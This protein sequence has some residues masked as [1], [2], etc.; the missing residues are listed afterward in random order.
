PIYTKHDPVLEN[1]L[2]A[3]TA[4]LDRVTADQRRK[5][6]YKLIDKERSEGKRSITD[7]DRRRWQLPEKGRKWEHWMVPF[8]TGPDWPKEWVEAVT[9][10]RRAWRAK[11]D[12]VN[13]CIAANAEQ[14]ELVDQPELVK[15]IIRVSGPFT[16]E[17]VQPPE[18]SIGGL[19]AGE[20]ER[21]E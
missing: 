20:P 1:K 7:A 10:Y 2:R 4:A 21:L 16:V 13:A 12:E 3:C 15:G 11:M 18:V 6:E 5:L 17:A 14:E 8:G 19:F 9:A